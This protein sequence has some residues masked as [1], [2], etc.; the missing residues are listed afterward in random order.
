MA[1]SDVFDNHLYERNF[2]ENE[3]VNSL[4]PIS[5]PEALF[6]GL[7]ALQA[8]IT[9]GDSEAGL[10][11]S[12]TKGLLEFLG[13]PFAY[14]QHYVLHGNTKAPDFL[15][16]R[17]DDD[18]KTFL[19]AANDK[20]LGLIFSVW[21]DKAENVPLDNGKTTRDNP[22]FQL[23]GYLTSLHLP[24]G[25]LG[26]GHEM[27]CMDTSGFFRDKRFLKVNFDKLIESRDPAALRIFMGI[28][29][30]QGHVEDKKKNTPAVLAADASA[31]Y[32]EQ[33]EAELRDAIYGLNGRESMFEKTGALLFASQET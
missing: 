21:E 19:E 12:F 17:N 27:I 7:K 16:F 18:R 1:Y 30:Y 32:R 25:F 28:F 9:P 11:I 2:F 3:I 4:P 14:Q 31:K 10:D 5:D 13:W 29:G 20:P 26:N 23:F 6:N 8:K 22:Y 24:F 15:L 33:S